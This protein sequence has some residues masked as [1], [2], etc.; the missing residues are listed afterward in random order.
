MTRNNSLRFFSVGE[1]GLFLGQRERETQ[2]VCFSV[3]TASRTL[4]Y[5][6]QIIEFGVMTR[7]YK[8][9]RKKACHWSETD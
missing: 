6:A 8:Q 4:V 7:S 2:C 3:T 1:G 5:I 9:E